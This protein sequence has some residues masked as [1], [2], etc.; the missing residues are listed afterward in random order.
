M[1]ADIGLNP[2][3]DGKLIRLPVPSLTEERRKELVKFI[4][5]HGEEAKV[6]IRNVRR[7][8]N[9]H[10]KKLEKEDHVSEDEVKKALSDVQKTTDD[11]TKEVDEVVVHK[12]KEIM[13]V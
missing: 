4:K 3:N 6:A 13:T 9:E 7:D 2:T 10:L 5:K 11:F 1:R 8:V 12:E